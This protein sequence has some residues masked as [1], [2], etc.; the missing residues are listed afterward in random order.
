M[1]INVNSPIPIFLR[2]SRG[3]GDGEKGRLGSDPTGPRIGKG[4]PVGNEQQQKKKEEVFKMQVLGVIM[5]I[6]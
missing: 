1:K 6:F 2:G 4:V 3:E 5:Y